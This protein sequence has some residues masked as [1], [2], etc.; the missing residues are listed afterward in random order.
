MTPFGLL[1]RHWRAQKQ[2]TLRDQAAFLGV[3]SAY[4]SALEHGKRGKP[5]FAMV[6]QICVFF[7]LIWD[8]AET[9]KQA[10]SLSHPKPTIDASSLSPQAVQLA[11][12]LAISIDRLSPDSCAALIKE[13]DKHLKS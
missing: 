4:L 3:S 5:S 13:L 10:A 7:D 2:K 8:E 6:D 11:N 9:I 12:Q 1:M